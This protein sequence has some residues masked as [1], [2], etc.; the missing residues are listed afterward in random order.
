MAKKIFVTYEGERVSLAELARLTG[1]PYEAIIYRYRK[2]LRGRAL[3]EPEK[4]VLTEAEKLALEAWRQAQLEQR[5]R[6]K[7]VD[8][9]KQRREAIARIKREHAEAMKWTLIPGGEYAPSKRERQ[10]IA[11][12]VKHRQ[13][14]HPVVD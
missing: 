1:E 2:G 9:A 10:E 11:E 8:R 7:K 14:W 3:W 12:R 13:R 5:H 6:E 4:A